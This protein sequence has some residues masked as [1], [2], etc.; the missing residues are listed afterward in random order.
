MSQARKDSLSTYN[1]SLE[2]LATPQRILQSILHGISMWCK[3]EQGLLRKQIAPTI[4]DVTASP[5]TTA[6]NEQT[7]VIGWEAFLRGHVGL[8]WGVAYRA[9]YTDGDEEEAQR[10]LGDLIK[11]TLDFS[12][13]L[14]HRGNG[15]I[16]GMDNS[17][18]QRKELQMI[19]QKV[20]CLTRSLFLNAFNS[21]G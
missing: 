10:W 14:W 11:V 12:L 5:L 20:I 2:D 15:I 1:D 13:S 3:V 7:Q 8:S 17:E 6:Y 16:H 21:I 19:Q 4:A 9:H 18:A